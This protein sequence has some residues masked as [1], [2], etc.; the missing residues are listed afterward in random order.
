MSIFL[1]RNLTIISLKIFSKKYLIKFKKW[2]WKKNEK[3][4]IINSS[5]NQQIK[6]MENLLN[7]GI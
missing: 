2:Y 7:Q 1:L 5:Y 4:E 6:E 3:K